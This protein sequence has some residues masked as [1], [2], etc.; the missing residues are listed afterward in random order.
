MND[1]LTD[2]QGGLPPDSSSWRPISREE[3]DM[4]A[5]ALQSAFEVVAV[6]AKGNRRVLDRIEDPAEM[7]LEYSP[8]VHSPKKF[9]FPNWEKLFRFRLGGRVLL[10]PERAAS[11]RVIFGMHP[12]DL[13]AVRVLD[14]CLFD[15][16]ADSAYRAKREVTILIGVDCVPDE[17]CFCTSMGTDRAADGFD[18]FFHRVAGGYLVQTGSRRGE[19]LL[20]LYAPTVAQRPSEPPLP[21]QAKPISHRLDFVSEDLAPLMERVYDHPVWEELGSRCLGCGAC[22]MLCPSCY[23]FNVEDRL[24]LDLVGGERVRTWDSCQFD[25]FTKVAGGDEFRGN[26]ADR[27][28]HRFFRKYKYLW[29]KYQRTACV[30]CGRCS[31]EC[32]SRIDPVAVL[33]R[34]HQEQSLPAPKA[35][36]AAE[37]RPELA[38]IL[39]VESLT[40]SEKLFRLRMP[41]PLEFEPG[42]F[43]EISV[44]GQ[45]EAPFTIASAPVQSDE[46]EVVVR[47]AGALT[48]AMH[49]LRPG[50][51]VGVRG[52]FGCGFPLER[53]NGRDLLVVAGGM[54]MITLRSLVLGLLARRDDYGRIMLLYGARTVDHYLFRDELLSWHREGS[55]D[56]RFAV[57]Q[58][59][60]S[61][62][63]TRGDVAHLFKD[64][65]LDPD[66]V[67][68]V[69]SGPARMYR[70]VNPL[71]FRWGV[72][73]DQLY[74][75]LERHM[76]CGLGK[77]GK[78][79]INDICV[80]ESGPIF[81]YAQVKHLKEAIE[82]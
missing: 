6:K 69:V 18:L 71:L 41:H 63:V 56:C 19:R 57:T 47:A 64:L 14:D 17:H 35:S 12:C 7:I 66:R 4:F 1:I 16:E 28:R 22:T 49:R 73:E 51:T 31:R 36:P 21:L 5:R 60:N 26:Q 45:G 34:L 46:I 42:E 23:C 70:A 27:Q 82:R 29:D 54:G 67:T 33:N 3:I 62:G 10:E 52:P 80:C 25:Q 44:F 2:P 40:E 8:Q 37:Y 74:L 68:T 43:L 81:P 39:Y 75:N 76:K 11:P 38:E 9:L 78:C 65:D 55:M 15:G 77:C 59:D 61:W 58:G 50:D 79:R 48:Q 32:L 53:F 72:G 30:G 24:D 13:H 20:Y